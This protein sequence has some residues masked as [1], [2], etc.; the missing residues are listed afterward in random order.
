MRPMLDSSGHEMH[1][2][3]HS[4]PIYELDSAA[5]VRA[6]L[7]AYLIALVGV[8]FIVRA[9]LIR[10]RSPKNPNAEIRDRLTRHGSER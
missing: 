4:Y 9:A 6:N 5:T 7:P 2:D 8:G 3:G 10:F 1:V